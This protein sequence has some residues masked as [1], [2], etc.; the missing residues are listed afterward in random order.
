[1]AN[2]SRGMAGV[3]HGDRLSRGGDE[4]EGESVQQMGVGLKCRLDAARTMTVRVRGV[5][6]GLP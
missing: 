4:A 2:G 6:G 1:M 3:W 5:V